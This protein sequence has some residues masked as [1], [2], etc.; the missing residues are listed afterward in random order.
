MAMQKILIVTSA[1]ITGGVEMCAIN[2]AENIDSTKYIKEFCVEPGSVK[3]LENRLK[4][5]DIKI[6]TRNKGSKNI[7]KDYIEIKKVIKDGNYDIVHSH[8]TFYSGII[9]MAAKKCGVRKRVAHAHATKPA[10][11]KKAYRRMMF[12]IYRVIMRKLINMY[13]TDL[14]ACGPEAGEFVFGKNK[15]QKRG[16]LLNNGINLDKNSYDEKIRNDARTELGIDKDTVVFGHVG[17]INYV[18]NHSFLLDIFN[19]YLNIN[20][21]AKLLLVGDGIK[22]KEIEEKA[23]RLGFSDKLIITGVRNDVERMLMAMDIMVFPS[24]HEGLPLALVEAQATK[25]P[26]LI[27]S[28]VTYSAKLNDNVSYMSLEDMPETWAMQAQMLIRQNR[29]QTDNKKVKEEYDIKSV[30]KKLENIY[31]S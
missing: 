28:A 27:S 5:N 10:Q 16:M 25:L 4:N 6:I 7:I 12:R 20:R 1:L 26:C 30:A 31:L 13:A 9:M 17:T 23:E 21:N 19:E 29:E 18:K 11:R 22:R 8:V 15:F 14:V 3:E 24:F 2:L